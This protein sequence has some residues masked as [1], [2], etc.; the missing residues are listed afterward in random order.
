MDDL[1]LVVKKLRAGG[2]HFW[3]AVS[4]RT[5]VPVDTIIKIARRQTKD[6]RWQTIA[7]LIKFFKRA[8][9]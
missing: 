6:P 7:P 5:G 2:R 9:S 3:P 8:G 4:E 1:E